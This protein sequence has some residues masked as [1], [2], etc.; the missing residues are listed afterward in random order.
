MVVMSR[1]NRDEVLDIVAFSKA[2][3]IGVSVLPV[4]QGAGLEHRS[5]CEIFR[6][7]SDE[8]R[9]MSGVFREFARLRRAGEPLWEYSGFYEMAA[10]YVAGEP[11]GECDAGRLFLDLRANGDLAA[12]VD[13][14]AFASLETEPVNEAMTRISDQRERIRQC[15]EH[16]PCCYTCTTNVTITANHPV[17]F[18][19]E[20]ARI[21][22]R[23]GR[24]LPWAR[25]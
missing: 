2:R 13:L 12:C 9:E 14:P 18:A 23:G 19:L 20:G 3:R 17:R 21:R 16:T 25:G 22:R 5:E 24:V 7:S 11:I 10:K 15:S 8:Q 4:A 1:V 6:A